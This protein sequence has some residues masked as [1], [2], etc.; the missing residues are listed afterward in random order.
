MKPLPTPGLLTLDALF[1]RRRPLPEVAGEGAPAPCL[2]EDAALSSLPA[3]CSLQMA[4]I[5]AEIALEEG[6]RRQYPPR[7]EA[8]VLERR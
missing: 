4:R 6:G 8:Q 7:S 1:A 3:R 5:A 2:P